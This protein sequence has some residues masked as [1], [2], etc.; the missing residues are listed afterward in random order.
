[1]VFLR[2]P[3]RGFTTVTF[4]ITEV[5]ALVTT[6]S[7]VNAP[8]EAPKYDAAASGLLLVLLLLVLLLQLAAAAA[9]VAGIAPSCLLL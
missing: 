1:M 5:V 2:P 4:W 3:T 9:M 8:E 6:G 7:A